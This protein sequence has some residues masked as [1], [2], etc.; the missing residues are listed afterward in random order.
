M[1]RMIYNM[2]EGLA[3]E[4]TILGAQHFKNYKM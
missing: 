3:I 1:Y 4:S 2:L